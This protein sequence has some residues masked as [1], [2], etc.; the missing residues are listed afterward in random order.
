MGLEVRAVHR[1][2]A[3]RG[4]GARASKV[5]GVLRDLLQ[6]VVAE[7]VRVGREVARVAHVVVVDRVHV[8]PLRELLDQRDE[9]LVGVAG[10]AG[11]A[12]PGQP[13]RTAAQD[14]GRGRLPVGAEGQPLRMLL[15]HVRVGAFREIE[16]PRVHGD[17]APVALADQDG[18]EVEV[19]VLRH[20]RGREPL[21]G[22]EDARRGLHLHDERVDVRL[23]ELVDEGHDGGLGRPGVAWAGP[24]GPAF[25]RG[26]GVG[27][28][29]GE[30][31]DREAESQAEDEVR[32]GHGRS[33]YQKGAAM[34]TVRP[35]SRP[36]PARGPSAR[37]RPPP[38]R[39]RGPW[40]SACTARAPGGR[41]GRHEPRAG[42]FPAP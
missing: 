15:G 24:D 36:R 33:F 42:V 32:E 19:A 16:E 26:C 38:A 5:P 35:V 23:C 40:R 17:L 34:G 20:H 37:W 14:L 13:V 18:R 41:P 11:R 21:A 22:P 3:A 8:V 29:A 31:G 7:A 28:R 39:R 25:Q 9:P 2:R 10:A 4:R 27:F 12:H 1:A 30:D 6:A